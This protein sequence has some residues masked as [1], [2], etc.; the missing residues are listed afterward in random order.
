[1]MSFIIIHLSIVRS[2]YILVI[3]AQTGGLA[4]R[5]GVGIFIRSD[6]ITEFIRDRPTTNFFFDGQCH[7][8][9]CT[10]AWTQR[11]LL[12]QSDWFENRLID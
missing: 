4:A 2:T 6:S 11:S 5:F 12:T 9:L 10:T 3:H 8:L 7:P 1:M